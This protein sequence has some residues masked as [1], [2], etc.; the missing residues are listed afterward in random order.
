FHGD[1]ST[2]TAESTDDF[3]LLGS[4]DDLF[5]SD[6][7]DANNK[8]VVDGGAGND[9]AELNFASTSASV[10][11]NTDGSVT[12]TEANGDVNTFIEFEH[13]KFTDGTKATSELFAPKVILERDQDDVINSDRSTVGYT[14]TLPVGAV[15]GAMLT[16]VIEG[17][18]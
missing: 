7:N 16:I 15:V 3:V 8:L 10:A 13:F 18:T 11:L 4:G 2:V 17:V 6:Q 14:I 9:T 5:K 1:Y 12:I